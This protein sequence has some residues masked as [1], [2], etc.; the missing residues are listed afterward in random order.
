MAELHG[1]RPELEAALEQA[2]ATIRERPSLDRERHGIRQELDRD[3]A[4][5]E[6]GLVADPPATS[7]TASA[8]VPNT[9]L[10]PAC[11]TGGGPHRPALR[12]LRRHHARA[13]TWLGRHRLRRQSA[14]RVEGLR[15]PRPQ[16]RE[17]P[18]DRTRG[19][20]LVL[21]RR[22]GLSA[23]ASFSNR[24][25]LG[26][27]ELSQLRSHPRRLDCSPRSQPGSRTA[28]GQAAPHALV[29]S[30]PSVSPRSRRHRALMVPTCRRVHLR[31]WRTSYDRTYVRRWSSW[32][33][34]VN[35][36]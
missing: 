21:C 7:L 20:E 15:E 33:H 14:G 11:G 16:R 12:R 2:Q 4:A 5:R 34:H 8:R 28:A 10:P 23:V 36:P 27:C 24:E 18:C 1:H 13:L 31:R 19:L 3:L 29:A 26:G 22:A 9:V 32:L 6:P 25:S 17:G 35:C 30:L